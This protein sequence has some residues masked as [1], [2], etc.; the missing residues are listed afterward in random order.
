MSGPRDSKGIR[1][2]NGKVCSNRI[3][4]RDHAD[5]H[6]V[7]DCHDGLVSRIRRMHPTWER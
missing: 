5:R 7:Q 2:L 6:I 4:A 3:L 1:Y